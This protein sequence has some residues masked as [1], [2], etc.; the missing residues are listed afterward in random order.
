MKYSIN[1]TVSKNGNMN[2]LFNSL[3]GTS[4]KITSQCLDV[5]NYAIDNNLSPEELMPLLADEEDRNYFSQLFDLLFNL[6][7]IVNKDIT[8]TNHIEAVT[9]E[10][11]HRCNLYCKHCSL[12]AG[13]M[14]DKELFSTEQEIAL[15]D[16][17]L[18]FRPNVIIV[19]G[20]EPMV[21]S[22]F[23]DIINYIKENSEAKLGIMTNATLINEENV[24]KLAQT[25]YSFDLSL[26][27]VNEET[28]SKIRGKNVF[29]RVMKAV[30]L[31]KEKMYNELHY[32]WLMLLLLMHILMI[33]RN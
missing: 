9:I 10:L 22:D 21:R 8:E 19:T 6:G 18:K 20:G 1:A 24:D 29:G 31:L 15:I 32:L 17:I 23:W 2:L 12:S 3:T 25:F 33:L 5:V 16:Q 4:T 14:S 11:T 13:T 27:G 7:I 26:D 30:S 28:C